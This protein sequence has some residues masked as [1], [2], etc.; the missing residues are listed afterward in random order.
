M[1]CSSLMWTRQMVGA[2]HVGTI[3]D[4]KSIIDCVGYVWVKCLFNNLIPM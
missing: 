4:Y 3:F 2:L 1:H